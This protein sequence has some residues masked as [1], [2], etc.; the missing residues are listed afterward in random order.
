MPTV[1][2]IVT[3]ART[4]HP[5]DVAV[6]DDWVFWTD[7]VAHGVFRADKRAGGAEQLRKDVPRPMGLVAVVPEPQ[8]CAADP[9]AE[10]NGGCADSCT[11]DAAG[12]AACSCGPGRALAAD[13]RSCR[14]AALACPDGQF[15]CAEGRCL[16]AELVCDGVRHCSDRADTSDEDLFYCSECRPRPAT[17]PSPPPAAAEPRVLQRRASAPRAG[18]AAARAGAA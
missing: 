5:F 6:V 17:R 4:E 15:A 10:L 1:R 12:R 8:R 18:C 3:Q 14:P 9:C 7:W 2:Q 13:R 16:P 11:A